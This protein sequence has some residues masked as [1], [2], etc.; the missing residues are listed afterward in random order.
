MVAWQRI[1]KHVY[2]TFMN[3]PPGSISSIDWPL[4]A[5]ERSAALFAL[6]QQF[7]HTQYWA[8]E[9]IATSQFKQLQHV[10]RHAIQTVPYYAHQFVHLT[11][12]VARLC[13]A[14]HWRD[15]PLLTRRDVQCAGDRLYST[16]VPSD[17]GRV[18]TSATG[19]STSQPVITLG[20]EVT[21]R[22]WQACTL[23]DHAWQRRDLSGSL[24]SIRHRSD[25]C[26]LPPHGLHSNNWGA[27]TTGVQRTGPAFLLNVR[28]S[29]QQQVDWL[30]KVQPNY[31]LTYPSVLTA[32]AELLERTGQ[33]LTSLWEARSYGEV[34][35]PH[36]RSV[37]ES[38]FGTRVVDMYSSQEVGYIALQC[39]DTTNYHVQSESLLLEV[40]DDQGR[41]CQPGEVGRVIVTTLHNF[42]MPLIRYEIGDYAEVG[43]PCSCGRTLPVLKRILGR[44]RGLLVMPD[45]SRRWPVFDAGERPDEL[46]PFF[47]FQVIQRSREDV[48]VLTVRHQPLSPEERN[49]VERYMVQTLGAPFRV[50]VTEVPSIP[51]SPSGKFEDFICEVPPRDDTTHD[52]SS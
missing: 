25:D 40:I 28:S 7:S 6:A 51:R 13:S 23:R 17:H 12:D 38:I 5:P 26:A 20:T 11:S 49:R 14:A 1:S 42:A 18:S 48:E 27:A 29:V 52:H 36:A 33:S 10:L 31:L 50:R 8:E 35:E 47:Q 30:L 45:G 46:P 39:P 3:A 41:A 32:V 21:R 43:P 44:Q 9:L 15:L 34:L 24:A 4:I 22:L 2:R 37:C 16:R 19:G